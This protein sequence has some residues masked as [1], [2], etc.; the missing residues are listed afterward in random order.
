MLHAGERM[1]VAALPERFESV[2]IISA[3]FSANVAPLA[4]VSAILVSNAMPAATTASAFSLVYGN[5]GYGVLAD[6]T[7]NDQIAALVAGARR[8]AGS[9]KALHCRQGKSPWAV[10]EFEVHAFEGISYLRAGE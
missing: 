2:A 6:H 7:V 8:L 4:T 9:L 3:C 10:T 5:D 1:F